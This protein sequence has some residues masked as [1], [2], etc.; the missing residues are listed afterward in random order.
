MNIIELI[1]AL[2]KN[3]SLLDTIRNYDGDIND[4]N[5]FGWTALHY[6]CTWT[7]PYTL[8]L[9]QVL[10]NKG[11][12][13]N[14]QNSEGS[15][16]LLYVLRFGYPIIPIAKLLLEAGADIYIGGFYNHY[17]VFIVSKQD[18]A[19]ELLIN[20]VHHNNQLKSLTLE[21]MCY[22]QILLQNPTELQLLPKYILELNKNC[23]NN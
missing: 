20:I 18:P 8:D 23:R 19:K 11:I 15:T 21:Q 3:P 6:A 7:H 10:F 2:P 16:A 14:L 5:M 13:V 4:I 9:I 12:D 1:K 17:D 22:K